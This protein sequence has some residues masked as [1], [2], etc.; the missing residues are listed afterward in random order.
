MSPS[1]RTQTPDTLGALLVGKQNKIITA[2]YF[3]ASFSHSVLSRFWIPF[4]SRTASINM[5]K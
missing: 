3:I 5:H 1:G 2:V 4:L